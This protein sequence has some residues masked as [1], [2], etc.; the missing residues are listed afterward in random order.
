MFQY[1]LASQEPT[2]NS[3]PPQRVGAEWIVPY[4][5]AKMVLILNTVNDSFYR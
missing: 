1:I 4:W 5:P 3:S 2:T